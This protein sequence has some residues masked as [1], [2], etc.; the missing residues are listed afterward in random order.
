MKYTVVW[1][2]EA[3]EELAVIWAGV[4]DREAV[5]NAANALDNQLAR[6]PAAIGESRPHAE[7]IVHYLPLG[8]RFTI[9]DGDRL[10]KVVAVWHCRH[11]DR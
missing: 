11:I 5:A 2:A 7:R 8:A 6:D 4:A 10:V 3:E 9:L 1:V